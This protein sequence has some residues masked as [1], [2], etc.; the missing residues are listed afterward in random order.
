MSEGLDLMELAKRLLDDSTPFSL[1]RYIFKVQ[2]SGWNRLDFP[3]AADA[4]GIDKHTVSRCV[5]RLGD[6]D[7]LLF[8]DREL[9]INDSFL[10]GASA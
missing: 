4:L 3:E 7:V 10:I 9:K 1:V 5:K 2:G 8:H 6:M